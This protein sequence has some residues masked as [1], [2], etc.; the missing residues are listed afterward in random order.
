[1]TITITT[2]ITIT[3]T[4]IIITIIIIIIVIIIII[5][6]FPSCFLF[7]LPYAQIFGGAGSF[8]R[9]HFKLINGFSNKFWGW[10]GE[11]D[12]LYKRYSLLTKVKKSVKVA[13][14]GFR[15]LDFDKSL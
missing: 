1:M 8:S 3:I 7:S 10:G 5:I 13:Q 4:T 14:N 2:T 11:D 6:I 12:D 9:E 15:Q